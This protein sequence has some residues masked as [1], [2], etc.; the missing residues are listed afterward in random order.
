MITTVPLKGVPSAFKTLSTI[1]VVVCAPAR[2]TSSV[3]QIRRVNR[4]LSLVK[5]PRFKAARIPGATL[6]EHETRSERPPTLLQV[7]HAADGNTMKIGSF[8]K[9]REKFVPL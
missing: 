6:I 5:L 7:R 1:C 9:N 8:G 4:C 3:V 2:N